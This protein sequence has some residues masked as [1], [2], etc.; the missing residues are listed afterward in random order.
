MKDGLLVCR[1]DTAVAD[2]SGHA[3]R[4]VFRT[5][6]LRWEEQEM[7]KLADRG[8]NAIISGWNTV[9][10]RG[11][12]DR[13]CPGWTKAIEAF[14]SH[15]LLQATRLLLPYSEVDRD[16]SGGKDGEVDGSG[17]AGGDGGGEG[18]GGG[19]GGDDGAGEGDGGSVGGGNGA[20][21]RL[22]R[23]AADI[24]I[25]KMSNL[26]NS[27][28]KLCDVGS[29]DGGGGGEGAEVGEVTAIAVARGGKVTIMSYVDQREVRSL[30][31]FLIWLA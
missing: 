31:P 29:L 23:Q 7:Q 15:S 18:E 11:E 14:G 4:R 2:E 5:A 24:M 6:F 1:G 20:A 8:T 3:L 13:H 27:E 30:R 19:A 25:D 22:R 12:V 17:G 26:T 10:L 21:A 28:M 9:G 16:G